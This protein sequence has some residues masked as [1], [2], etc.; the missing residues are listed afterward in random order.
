MTD[1]IPLGEETPKDLLRL[2]K[3][4]CLDGFAKIKVAVAGDLM[5]DRY[6]SGDVNRISPEAPVPVVRMTEGKY[7]LGGAGNVASNLRGMGAEVSL[8]S[9][10]G[11]DDD[12]DL[13][14]GLR[15]ADGIDMSGVL[16]RNDAVTTVKTRI[17][18]GN[19][20]QMLRIDREVY[21]EPDEET[22]QT[23]LE[24]IQCM[25]EG[26]TKAVIISDYGKGFCCERMCREIISL[27]GKK[28]VPVFVDPK[29][30]DWSKYRGAF[31]VTPNVRELSDAVGK[32]VA[33][34]DREVAAA[35]RELSEKYDLGSVLVT[36]S[37]KGATFV[38]AEE[39]FHER[40]GGKEVYDVSGA[41]DTMI[42]V[43][44]AFVAA[45]LN[46]RG[47][48]AAANTAAQTVIQKFGTAAVT[49][50][51]LLVAIEE[52]IDSLPGSGFT[53]HKIVSA[54]EAAAR[55][56]VWKGAGQRVVFTNGC[57]DILHAGHLDSL[58]MA[59]ELGDRLVV[60]LN[61]DAS[62]RRLKGNSRPVNC[63]YDRAR[64]LAG[65]QTVDLVVIFAEETPERL[66]SQICPNVI[67]KGGDY[68]AEQVAGGRYADE[69]VILPLTGGYSTTEIIRRISDESK[70]PP[71]DNS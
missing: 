17:L 65:L 70:Q 14:L 9:V 21:S 68:T 48:V 39:L 10:I 1:K 42:S 57:F 36:R 62:T 67:A 58:R 35:A 64:V 66:L 4:I 32:E 8:V 25:L 41:G 61:S 53:E 11:A 18:G 43:M 54:S 12:A 27:C 3:S 28:K 56:A 5:L 59:R 15:A 37:D 26:G 69:V 46:P 51:E 50:G 7:T 33:N 19:G 23:V 63:Q 40:C 24:L 45:G 52:S 38:S 16:Q 71:M 22:T 55:C 29:G 20:K 30:R 47:S 34:C 31:M 44:T 49:Y 6:I 2:A 60:G 13:L